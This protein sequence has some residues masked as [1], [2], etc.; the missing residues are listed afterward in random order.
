MHCRNNGSEPITTVAIVDRQGTLGMPDYLG[1][2]VPVTIAPGAIGE[3]FAI[4]ERS[5]Y[6]SHQDFKINS[7]SPR[8][9]EIMAAQISMGDPRIIPCSETGGSLP[10][11]FF[12]FCGSDPER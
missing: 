7:A 12:G 6:V 9:L 11:S 8:W 4:E 2:V 5:M 10:T 1:A 3:V